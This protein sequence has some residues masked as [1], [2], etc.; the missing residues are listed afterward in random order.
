MLEVVWGGGGGVVLSVP[1]KARGSGGG[2]VLSVPV[3]ARGSGGGSGV[4]CTC[5]C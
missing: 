1:V 4:E 2:V 3:K 5:E